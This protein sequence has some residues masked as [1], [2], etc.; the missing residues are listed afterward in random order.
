MTRGDEVRHPSGWVLR[1]VDR[2]VAVGWRNVIQQAPEN[3]GEAWEQIISDP[4]RTT[5][6]QHQLKGSLRT[7]MYGGRVLE[8]WQYEVTGAGR[9]WYLIDDEDLTLWLVHASTGHPKAT[10]RRT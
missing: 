3:A 6:R 9:L 5:Q 2:K 4:R 7:G 8:Q 1:Y 10:E